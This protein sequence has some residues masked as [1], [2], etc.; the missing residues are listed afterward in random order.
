M[1]F[2]SAYCLDVLRQQLMCT[3]DTGVVGQVWIYPESPEPHVDFES[4]HKCKNFE[5]IRQWVQKNQIP[6]HV[7]EDFLVQPGPGDQVH[8]RMP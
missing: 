6:E 5:D 2:F 3:V 1:P 4:D 7:P 8:K